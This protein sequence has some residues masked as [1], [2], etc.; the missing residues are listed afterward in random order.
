MVGGGLSS[1]RSRHCLRLELAVIQFGV[2]S[3]GL[4]Q[5]LV[6]ALLDDVPIAHHQNQVGVADG[7]QA[8][9]NDK[10]GAALHQGIHGAL[11]QYLG[12]RINRTGC[13]VQN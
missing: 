4:Q 3:A 13:L 12:A 8:V 5:A 10:A 9:G 2:E 1:L 6:V 7:G 11:D